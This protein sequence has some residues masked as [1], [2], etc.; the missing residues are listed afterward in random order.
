MTTS[1]NDHL[2]RCEVHAS[3]TERALVLE[4]H[5]MGQVALTFRTNLLSDTNV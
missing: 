2:W 4:Q 3:V 1:E 5:V